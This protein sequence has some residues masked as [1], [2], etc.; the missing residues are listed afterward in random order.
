[1]RLYRE[2]LLDLFCVRPTFR[3]STGRLRS[4]IV[5]EIQV[6]F[7]G[8]RKSQ[9]HVT[10]DN[11]QGTENNTGGEEQVHNCTAGVVGTSLNLLL[12]SCR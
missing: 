4:D 8:G 12:T 1:M 2:Q 6:V 10:V 9:S 5:E 3:H 7:P 11:G